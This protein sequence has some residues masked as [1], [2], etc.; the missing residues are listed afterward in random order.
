MGAP[1]AWSAGGLPIIQ[2]DG[3]TRPFLLR[4]QEPELSRSKVLKK[5]ICEK[6]RKNP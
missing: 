2:E 3:A 5:K 4:P 1:Q 6:M